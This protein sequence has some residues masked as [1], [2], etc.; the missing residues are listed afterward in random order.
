MSEWGLQRSNQLRTRLLLSFDEW[1][2]RLQLQS[3]T[4][5]SLVFQAFIVEMSEAE[6]QS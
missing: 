5:D 2:V 4:F 6:I 1:S 3:S